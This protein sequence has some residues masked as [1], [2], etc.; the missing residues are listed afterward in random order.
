MGSA[1]CIARASSVSHQVRISFSSILTQEVSVFCV[2]I[3][4]SARSVAA[5]SPTMLTSIG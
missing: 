3:G 5:L 2:S 1:E 4:S